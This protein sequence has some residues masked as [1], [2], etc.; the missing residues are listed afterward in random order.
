MTRQQ[1]AWH[2]RPYDVD[3]EDSF[4]DHE[5]VKEYPFTNILGNTQNVSHRR[6][7]NTTI[8]CAITL[9][10]WVLAMIF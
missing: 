2:H 5:S 6:I 9:I 4:Y 1:A 7:D 8:F 10:L 3:A